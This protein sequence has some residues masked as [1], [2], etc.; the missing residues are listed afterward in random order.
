MRRTIGHQRGTH[1][2][3][4]QTACEQSSREPRSPSAWTHACSLP[5]SVPAVLLDGNASYS[6]TS[7]VLEHHTPQLPSG[8]SRC[9]WELIPLHNE[10]GFDSRGHAGCSMRP[11]RYAH[12]E[13]TGRGSPSHSPYRTPSR[14]LHTRL[15]PLHLPRFPPRTAAIHTCPPVS[16]AGPSPTGRSFLR[17]RLRVGSPLA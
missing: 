9:V 17:D 15:T 16:D 2:S 8:A 3:Q 1:E 11:R 7:P 5:F 10:R 12:P 13:S 4:N 14:H 6:I